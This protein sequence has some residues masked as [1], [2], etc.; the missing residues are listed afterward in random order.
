MKGNTLKGIL[1]SYNVICSKCGKERS[2]VLMWRC[3]CGAPYNIIINEIFE[4]G[5][6]FNRDRTIWRYRNFFPYVKRGKIISLGEGN[7]PLTKIE[8]NLWAKLDYLMPTGSYKDRGTSIL[9]SGLLS[10]FP[11]IKG[12]SEDSSGNAGA[13]VAAYCAKANIDLKIFVPETTSGVKLIQTKFYGAEVNKVGG[14]REEVSKKAQEVGREYLYVGHVWHPY[15]K[16]GIRTLAYE[17]V[18]QMNG[19]SFDYIYVPVSAGTLLIGL[20]EGFK[21]LRSSGI[22]N[23]IPTIVASQTSQ[24][25][26]LYHRLKDLPYNPPTRIESMADALVSTNPPLLDYMVKSIK[27]INGDTEIVE[28]EQIASAYIAL[29]RKGLFVE[30]SSAVIYATY[31]KHLNQGKV[32]KDDKILLILTGFGLKKI[33]F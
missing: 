32:R 24:V 10:D 5:K 33:P 27:E 17:I 12:L 1:M 23:D 18:E 28:E 8:N 19:D 14:S 25:S 7:T 13:S 21:H 29:A 22:I 6:I 15:F 31:L 26:P 20:I 11:K 3:D 2:N 9:I 16:D 30:P 4:K